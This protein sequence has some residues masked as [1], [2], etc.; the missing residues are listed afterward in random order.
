MILRPA[1]TGSIFLTVWTKV[2]SCLAG[3]ATIS[4]FTSR[5]FL[6]FNEH[7]SFTLLLSRLKSNL[8]SVQ[9]FIASCTTY[10]FNRS[11]SSFIF[12]LSA[13]RDKNSFLL[14]NNY[15]FFHISDLRCYLLKSD[16]GC[17]L[18]TN[19]WNRIPVYI[20]YNDFCFL[21][22]NSIFFE[23]THEVMV[24]LGLTILT[25][26]QEEGKTLWY[27]SWLRVCVSIYSSSARLFCYLVQHHLRFDLCSFIP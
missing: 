21:C 10:S 27:S 11:S 4:V 24:R 13:L 18:V 23:L 9:I 17:I 16:L 20:V 1:T 14:Q 6:S 15:S 26:S 22:G 7:N 25:C 8:L 12:S 2:G 3:K 5:S 19:L